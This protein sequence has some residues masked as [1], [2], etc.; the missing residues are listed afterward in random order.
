MNK[1][2]AVPAK[3]HESSDANSKKNSDCHCCGGLPVSGTSNDAVMSAGTNSVK[4]LRVAQSLKHDV[5]IFPIQSSAIR[6]ASDVFD[7]SPPGSF[8]SIPLRI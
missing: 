2:A 5:D 8:R 6:E 1:H 7:P 4:D 3:T